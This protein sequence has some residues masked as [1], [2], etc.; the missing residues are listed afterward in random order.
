MWCWKVGKPNDR[1]QVLLLLGRGE[2]H[3][4]FLVGK[5]QAGSAKCFPE[6]HVALDHGIGIVEIRR[7]LDVVQA[8][9]LHAFS[10]NIDAPNDVI[11]SSNCAT[12]QPRMFH[13]LGELQAVI[14][15]DSLA[16]FSTFCAR[17]A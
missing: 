7:R 12:A 16:S 14:F 3:R 15:R 9:A 2:I 8:E 4:Q 10:V 13:H 17:R 1:R 11:L 6:L 5:R